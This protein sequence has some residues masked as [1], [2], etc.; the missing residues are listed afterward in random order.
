MSGWPL[1]DLRLWT[2]AVE[3]RPVTDED[4][5]TLEGLLPADFEQDPRYD[6]WP[7][8]SADANRRRILRQSVWDGRGSWRPTAWQLSFT[9]RVSDIIV[10]LQVLE[11]PNW[12]IDRTVDSASWLA[13]PARGQGYGTD[14]RRA[15][16]ELAL[17]RLGAAAA[18]SSAWDDNVPS[19][20][21]SSRLGYEVQ[22]ARPHATADR[23]GTLVHV[24]LDAARWAS[25]AQGW[26]VRII[27]LD[28]CQDWFA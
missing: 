6:P 28:A 11:A 9:V 24:R 2:G 20:R 14:M 21:V 12:G 18:V 27:G 7:T 26:D 4:L 3:L 19:L 1:F 10:G 17:G 5:I 25:L 23:E 13:P 15:I 8:L 16:L 22:D